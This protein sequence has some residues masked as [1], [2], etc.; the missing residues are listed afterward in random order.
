MIIVRIWRIHSVAL[1]ALLL[2]LVVPDDIWLV[3]VLLI[4]QAGIVHRLR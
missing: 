1:A 2:L 4:T 3:T